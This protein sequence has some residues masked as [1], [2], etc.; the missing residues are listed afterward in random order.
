MIY[1]HF[2]VTNTHETILEYSDPF[3]IIL[4]DDV[5]LDC[6]KTMTNRRMDQKLEPDIVRPEMKESRQEQQ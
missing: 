4:V 5:Q 3:K 1:H 6:P 2:W